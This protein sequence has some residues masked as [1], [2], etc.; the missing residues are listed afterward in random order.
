MSYIYNLTDTWDNVATTFTAIGMNVTDTTSAATSMLID[1]QVGGTTQFHVLKNGA[2]HTKRSNYNITSANTAI[3]T[4]SNYSLTGTNAQSLADLSGTWNTSGTPTAIK[5]NMTDTA[6]N[7]ASALMDLQVGGVSQFKV[8]KAGAATITTIELGNA[9]DTTL[10]RAS[11]G[12]VAIEGSSILSAAFKNTGTSG[13]TVPLLD[14]A[15]TWSAAQTFTAQTL[16]KDSEGTFAVKI[17]YGAATGFYYI[18]TTNSASAPTLQFRN[19]AGTLRAALTDAGTWTWG[20]Y[21]AGAITSDAS[22]NITAVSDERMKIVKS[23]YTRGLADLGAMGPPKNFSWRPESGMETEG[24]YSGFIAQEVL[25]GIP[26]AVHLGKDGVYSFEDRP[27]TAALVNAVL[28]LE[29]RI[30]TL[31]ATQ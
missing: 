26:E 17:S 20:A 14:G 8:T 22:G 3:I 7:A 18:G 30:K 24:V 4:A 10:S 25:K 9:S 6:S 16:L 12:V 27:I 11:A 21:G 5:L 13:N 2:V 23:D 29:K 19:H 28:E 15:N 1:L 31:E